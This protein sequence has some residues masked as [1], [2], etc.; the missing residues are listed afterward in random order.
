[1]RRTYS[2]GVRAVFVAATASAL[3]WSLGGSALAAGNASVDHA[4]PA[5]H[6]RPAA[7]SVRRHK[8]TLRNGWVSSQ[9]VYDSGDPAVAIRGGI[10]Y[11][12][13]SMHQASGSSGIFATLPRGYRPAH[14][15]YLHV[16]TYNGAE[17]SLDIAPDGQM[18]AS[19]GRATEYTSLAGVSFP[20]GSVRMHTLRLLNG[21]ASS[22]HLLGTGDPQAGVQGGIEYLAG[23]MHQASGTATHFA[24]LPRTLRPARDM[25]LTDFTDAGRPGA[26]EVLTNGQMAAFGTTAP[27]FTSLSGI[28]FPF[29]T[30]GFHHLSLL[31]GWMPNQN[32]LGGPPVVGIRNGVVYFAGGVEQPSG[33]GGQVAT[34]PHA[35]WPAHNL[36]LPLFTSGGQVGGLE[37]ATDGAMFAFGGDAT[38][39]SGFAG[40]SYPV[41]S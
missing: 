10:V 23:S 13:G 17:G 35:F 9:P 37:I 40:I 12:S 2:R 18:L 1:M 20:V 5:G 32:A 14:L 33:Q 38:G 30:A 39:F 15:M 16:Y 6:A 19:D 28:S 7:I 3:T 22:Q 34:L 31:N 27:N 8:L 41:N 29:T 24:T 21:W 25:V 4:G 36:W 26:V 11:L